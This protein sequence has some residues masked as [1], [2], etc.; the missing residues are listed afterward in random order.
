MLPVS[1]AP[2]GEIIHN[3]DASGHIRKWSLELNGLDISDVPRTA[4]KSHAL[5]DFVAEW[6]E[7]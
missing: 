5:A 1:T 7:A 3:R 2:L 4:I 6:T